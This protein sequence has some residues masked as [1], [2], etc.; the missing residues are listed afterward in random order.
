MW[1]VDIQRI[2]APYDKLPSF[3]TEVVE[4][5]GA[6]PMKDTLMQSIE[7]ALEEAFELG[8]Q[9]SDTVILRALFRFLEMI[10]V[11]TIQQKAL[12][13]ILS[14]SIGQLL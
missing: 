3:L 14:R 7:E 13:F 11:S 9:F 10:L 8:F 1:L 6:A 2:V 5:V 12:N 4:N